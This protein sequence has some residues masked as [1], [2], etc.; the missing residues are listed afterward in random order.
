[1]FCFLPIDLLKMV[2][3]RESYLLFSGGIM[4]VVVIRIYNILLSDEG[5]SVR[6]DEA[7][8]DA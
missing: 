3:F 4:S 6:L 7:R 5:V 2:N 8:G 1:M